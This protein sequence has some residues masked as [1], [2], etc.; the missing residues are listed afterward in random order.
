MNA[1]TTPATNIP[2]SV[3]ELAKRYNQAWYDRDMDAI[4][5]LHTPEFDFVLRGGNGI[6]KFS[7]RAACRGAFAMLMRAWPDYKFEGAEL[8]VRKDFYMC[9]QYITGTL[10]EP[11]HMG[12]Q[13]YQPTGK[14]TRFLIVDL[15]HCEGNLIKVKDG[16]IDGLAIHH[17][18]TAK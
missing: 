18:L 15:M 1:R 2:S 13:T 11:W 14:P 6:A 16:W 10:V 9:H 4:L 12:G 8:I 17:S 5:A 3:E 7:G